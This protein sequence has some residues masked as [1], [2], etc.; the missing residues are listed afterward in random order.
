MGDAHARFEALVNAL[1]AELYRFAYW[2]SRD[3]S[4]AE[5]LVRLL[6]DLA[7]TSG[8]TLVVSLHAPDLIR[9]YFSRVI[10]L[11]DGQIQFDMPTSELTG[12]ALARLYDLDHHSPHQETGA[13]TP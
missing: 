7:A 13:E 8:K 6:T 12:P 1:A 11:R 10:G 2:L 5:D 4:R 9:R 3:R